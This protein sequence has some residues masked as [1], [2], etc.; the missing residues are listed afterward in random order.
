LAE[1]DWDLPVVSP[2]AALPDFDLPLTLPDI[3]LLLVLVETKVACDGCCGGVTKVR[4][5][6]DLWSRIY[7]HVEQTKSLAINKDAL[8]ASRPNKTKV[9][10]RYIYKQAIR[11]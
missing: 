7:T 6:T 11:E 5:E 4:K 8:S 3:L 1:R 9:T 10:C 2:P